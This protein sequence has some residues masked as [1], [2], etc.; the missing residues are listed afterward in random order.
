MNLEKLREE[1]D[2]LDK[3][4]LSL[5]AQR[6][7][8]VEKVALV[9]NNKDLVVD[10]KRIEEVIRRVKRLAKEKGLSEKIAE[11]LWRKLIELSIDHE[12]EI[13]KNQER[14]EV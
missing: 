9:K 6:Q 8:C 2:K 7:K 11:S 3:E 10:K 13:L 5:I 14:K 4:I 12:Y 1:I